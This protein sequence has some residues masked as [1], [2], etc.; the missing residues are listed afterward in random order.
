MEGVKKV[1][2][3]G[4]LLGLVM[5]GSEPNLTKAQSFCRM[6]KEGLKACLPSCVNGENN[7]DPPSSACCTAIS[8]ADLKCLCQYRDSGFLTFYGVDP[9]KAMQ[10][11]VKCKIMDSFHC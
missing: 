5:I 10:L 9:D 8:K 7:V 4:M 6:P 2:I 3:L 11:P 1:M